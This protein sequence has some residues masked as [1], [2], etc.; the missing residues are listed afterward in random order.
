[1]TCF[2]H[3]P[4]E[5]VEQILDCL[6]VLDPPNDV[7]PETAALASL[8][9]TSK[10]LNAL[11]TRRLYRLGHHQHGDFAL[12]ARTLMSRKD[13]GKLVKYLRFDGPGPSSSPKLPKELADFYLKHMDPAKHD[14]L[15]VSGSDPNEYL[16]PDNVYIELDIILPLCHNV[17][18]V[19]VTLES[20]EKAFTLCR[21]QPSSLLSIKRLDFSCTED[22]GGVLLADH[23]VTVTT[24]LRAAPNVTSLRFENAIGLDSRQPFPFVLGNLTEL[25]FSFSVFTS[26]GFNALL[27]LTPNLKKL[28][29]EGGSGSLIRSQE[30]TYGINLLEAKA[31]I[32]G[33]CPK[34]KRFHMDLDSVDSFTTG[35][36]IAGEELDEAMDWF[37]RRGIHV[38]Y[39]EDRYPYDC[40]IYSNVTKLNY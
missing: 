24:L 22:E 29:Y 27:A 19:D 39:V 28:E 32:A 8:N 33:N 7:Y 4:I 5:T 38:T 18:I 30:T 25:T 6:D 17:E 12:F 31:A 23:P 9:Q 3:L 36:S 14:P 16:F 10:A 21:P 1:M 40:R 37:A 34:L 35:V 26:Q 13:L 11:T 15:E 2:N 20:Y